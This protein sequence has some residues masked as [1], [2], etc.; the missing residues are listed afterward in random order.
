MQTRGGAQLAFEVTDLGH[1]GTCRRA[2]QKLA[3]AW[4]LSSTSV[5]H[6]GIVASELA[7]NL[8]IHGKGGDFVLQPI[9]RESSVQ[10][11]MLAIDR[12]PG[13]RRVEECM[14]DGHSTAGTAGNGLGA[15]K[16]LSTVFDIYSQLAKGTIVL[17]RVGNTTTEE[18]A[19][20]Y[21]QWGVICL[22]MRG[23]VECGDTW[24]I[25]DEDSAASLLIVDGL[26]HGPLA[27]TAATEAVRVHAERPFEDPQEI[28]LA[29]HRRLK[30]TR[31]AAAACAIVKAQ[32]S[33]IRYAGVGNIAGRIV[34]A[35]F[36]K[37]LMSHNGTLG[38]VLLR[39]QG[40]DYEWP[41]YAVLVMHSDGLS[42]RWS[43]ADY[44]GLIQS[45]PAVIAAVLLR[46]FSRG[47]DD[48]TIAVARRLQ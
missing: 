21:T 37:G 46:D 4:Q 5:G 7:T 43:L 10:I 23:E 19:A 25:A 34:A 12:G 16:R 33:M 11:E 27:A 2:A 26:G 29:L 6:I 35:E 36:Q 40:L 48:A 17:A 39:S 38:L 45:H 32:A 22:P 42:S 20:P 44:P 9:L 18:P 3:E 41:S 30:G 1:V 31:G 14:R 15:V 13:M 8:V 47:R 24:S 28:M